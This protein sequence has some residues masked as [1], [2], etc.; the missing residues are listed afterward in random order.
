VTSSHHLARPRTETGRAQRGRAR[1]SLLTREKLAARGFQ[2]DTQHGAMAV[3]VPGTLAGWDLS[4]APMAG[5][6]SPTRCSRR[7]RCS[8]GWL[9]RHAHRRPAV[10]EGE[11]HFA[12]GPVRPPR[13]SFP[14]ESAKA[15]DRFSNPDYARTLEQIAAEGIAGFYGGAIGARI[16][17]RLAELDGFLTLEDL[18]ANARRGSHRFRC[19]SV[20][21][22][23]WELPPSNQGIAALEML[24]ILEPFDHRIDGSQLGALPASPDRGEESWPTRISGASWATRIMPGASK[25]C[26][27]T[28][29]SRGAPAATWI[30]SG[31]RAGRAGSRAR[32]ER[33]GLRHGGGC[34]R[35]HGVIDQLGL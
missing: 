30:R 12:A 27:R 2:Q 16:V 33:D 14:A 28:G 15:G 31:P 24:R 35:Q 21:F 3:T 19:R 8:P 10:G 34:R 9:H 25:H 22:V 6:N 29:S 32:G 13:R 4:F 17:A 20:A 1:G 11:L 23:C 26:C 7:F 18:R 5:G